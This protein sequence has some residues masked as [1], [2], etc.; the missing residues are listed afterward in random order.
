MLPPP[1]R[2]TN[3]KAATAATAAIATSTKTERR[4]GGSM[5]TGTRMLAATSPKNRPRACSGLLVTKDSMIPATVKTASTIPIRT[6]MT[7]RQS[8]RRNSVIA[9]A[10][11]SG[12]VTKT[13]TA[14]RTWEAEAISCS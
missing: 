14:P 2:L 5:R 7:N 4:A 11:R 10:L 3:K 8:V 6:G 1:A 9:L 13:R 12:P